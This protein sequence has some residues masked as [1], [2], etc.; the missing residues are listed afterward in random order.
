M[1]LT[2]VYRGNRDF[3]AAAVCSIATGLWM[4]DAHPARPM[5]TD[6]ARTVDGKACQVESRVRNN[7]DSREHWALPTCNLP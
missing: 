6:D 7:R 5:I 1:R 3:A 4:P 2:T